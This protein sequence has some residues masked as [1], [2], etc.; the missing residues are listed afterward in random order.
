MVFE[1][2][3][4]VVHPTPGTDCVM[5]SLV[6]VTLPVPA[7]GVHDLLV[8]VRAVSVNPI[9]LKLRRSS[10]KDRVLGFDAAGTV[11]DRGQQVTGF[12]TGD[13]VYY[14]GDVRRS[15]AY[16]ALQVVDARLVAPMPRTLGFTEAAALPLSA[17]TAWDALFSKLRLD[18]ESRGNLWVTGAG[19]GLAS[20]AIQLVRA[21][22]SVTVVA[23][24]VRP[25]ARNWA[26]RL[27]AHHVLDSQ[28]LDE[29]ISARLPAGFDWVLSIAT[30]HYYQ[31]I[32]RNIRPHGLVVVLDEPKEIDVNALKSKSV[33][34]LW[35]SLYTD[36]L[37]GS[38]NRILHQERLIRLAELV[39]EGLV[40][41]TMGH[42]GGSIDASHLERAHLLLESGAATGKIVLSNG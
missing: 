38:S 24:T 22:T 10:R 30:D 27:G 23:S 34:W 29:E 36:L 4:V 42:H 25:E 21:M 26:I 19:G 28:H 7:L 8:D 17:L 35:E 39:D 33:G 6:D 13:A 16:S 37:Y 11:L 20:V 32:V 3:A 5:N 15:G 31:S 18:R 2:A 12:R 14:S 41:S 9:D 40:R 1:T